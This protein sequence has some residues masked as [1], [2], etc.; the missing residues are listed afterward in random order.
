MILTLRIENSCLPGNLVDDETQE[1]IAWKL[2]IASQKKT[3][4]LIKKLSHYF[5]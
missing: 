3:F 1:N 2:K 4:N 5:I